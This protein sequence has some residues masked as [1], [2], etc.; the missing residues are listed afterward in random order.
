[1]T[2]GG[3]LV[4]EQVM[5]EPWRERHTEEERETEGQRKRERAR[6]SEG[7]RG[8]EGER[9]KVTLLAQPET[10]QLLCLQ[11]CSIVTGSNPSTC[12]CR[13]GSFAVGKSISTESM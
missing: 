13:A 12:V 11:D 3:A 9:R 2:V 10:P 4:A 8:N 5:G 1:M 6:E 7:E